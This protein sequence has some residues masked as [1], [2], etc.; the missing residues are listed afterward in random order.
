MKIIPGWIKMQAKFSYDQKTHAIPSSPFVAWTL[1][2]W[3][4]EISDDLA[5]WML[6]GQKDIMAIIWTHWFIFWLWILS[7]LRL[8]R[9]WYF[10]RMNAYLGRMDRDS[11]SRKAAWQRLAGKPCNLLPSSLFCLWTSLFWSLWFFWPDEFWLTGW[12]HRRQQQEG[13]LVNAGR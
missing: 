13:N 11:S 12:S 5:A 8:P 4:F 10:G 6:L 7:K 9:D 1:Q 3:L 2:L